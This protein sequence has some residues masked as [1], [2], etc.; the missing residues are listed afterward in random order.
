MHTQMHSQVISRTSESLL[1]LTV[2]STF[3]D[4]FLRGV[5]VSS[6]EILALFAVVPLLHVAMLKLAFYLSGLPIF[7][8]DMKE[9]VAAAFTGA[10]K[11]LAFGLPLLKTVFS[12]DPTLALRSAPL[13]LLH[14]LQLFIGSVFVPIYKEKIEAA[15]AKGKGKAS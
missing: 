8:M 4:T 13:L 1:L 12:G 11:T 6:G 15:E 9:R 14:P 10:Q 5:G 7:G 2:Y 3:C